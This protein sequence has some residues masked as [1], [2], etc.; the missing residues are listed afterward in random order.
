METRSGRS[1]DPH[2]IYMTLPNK[3]VLIE[4]AIKNKK[5]INYDKNLNEFYSCN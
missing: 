3:R 4:F 2:I 5:T 1:N